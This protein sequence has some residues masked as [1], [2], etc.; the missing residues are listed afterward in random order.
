ME[1]QFKNITFVGTSHISKDSIKS[2]ERVIEKKKPHIIAIELDKS[3]IQ[4][5][6][7][8]SRRSL[9]LS[10]IRKMGFKGFLFGMTGAWIERKMGKLTG[11]TP[12][13]EMKKAIL[14]AK[15]EKLPVALIDQDIRLTLRNISKR[16]TW[17]EKFKF[18]KELIKA[19]FIKSKPIGFDI[20]KVPSEKKIKYLTKRMKK[21]FPSLYTSL[22]TDRDIYMSKNLY[23]ISTDNYD[24]RI[25]TILGAG[26]IDGIIKLLKKQKWSREKTAGKK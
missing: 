21:D 1:R 14:I 26:H 15:K 5:L 8:K 11:S 22:I 18:A 12:G 6:F 2:V 9:R 16:I 24:K 17:K 20:T 19:I 10:D 25:V 4:T 7:T 23:K 3:R 13:S